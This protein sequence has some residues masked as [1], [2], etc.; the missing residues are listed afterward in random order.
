MGRKGKIQTSG[1]G[2]E[3]RQD[4]DIKRITCEYSPDNMPMMKKEYDAFQSIGSGNSGF[5][6]FFTYDMLYIL[7]DTYVSADAE[8]LLMY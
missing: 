2:N 4:I 3:Q 6:L 1:R 5:S 8:F 7:I